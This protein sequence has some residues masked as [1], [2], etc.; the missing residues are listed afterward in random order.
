[1]PQSV[2]THHYARRLQRLLTLIN[3]IKTTPH[4]AP[5]ALYT[6][7]GISR[8]MFYK[9]CQVLKALG[10]AFHYD[11]QQRRYIITQD[12]YLPVLD[13]STSEM[14]ALIMAVR[15]MASTGD[16]TLTY[17]AIAALRKVISNTPAEIRAFLQASLDDVVLQDGFG[18]N[19]TI[20]HDLW[21]ACQGQQR[22]GI[23]YDRGDGPRQWVI[24]PYQLFFK[25]RA[26]YLDACVVETHQIYMFRVNRI[27]SL[28][29]LGVCTPTPLVPYNFRERHRHSFSV[30]VGHPPQ[31]VRIRFRPAV[32]QYITE[33]RWHT[34]QQIDDL[35]DGSFIF[36]VEVSEPREVGWWALQWGANAE[37]L[38]PESL[39]QEMAQTARALV[40][41][42]ER[43][44]ERR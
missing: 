39:R 34:S 10:L 16:Y 2:T 21:S 19:G 38:E 3:E 12:R 26:L 1:M 20:L 30:F 36:T 25:R 17:E 29:R 5:E 42:Y 35:P 37:V 28:T 31:R 11:R 13:L 14:L 6:S 40:A 43:R 18:C 23:V 44:E 7:L 4:Q 15:Q 22:L 24:D 27:K 32:R 8:A 41:V 33:T 9:D